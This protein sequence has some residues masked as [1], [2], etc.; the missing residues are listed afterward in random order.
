MKQNTKI[1]ISAFAISALAF[2]TLAQNTMSPK[3]AEAQ[4]ASQGMQQD[5]LVQLNDTA[6]ASEVIGMEVKNYQDEKLGT[7]KNL[8]LDMES[9]RVV[10]VIVSTGGLLGMDAT[11]TPVPP[12]ALHHEVGQN[13][14]RIDSS[15]DKFDAAPKCDASKWEEDT[16]SNRVTEVYNYYGQ[17]PYYTSSFST[18]LGYVQKASKLM[19][20]PV[21]NAQGENLGKIENLIVDLSGGR[22]VAVII[23]SG[24]Y[25]GMDGE[26]SA[27]PPSALQYNAEH[28]TLQL[29]ASKEMLSSSPHFNANEWPNFNQPAY[30]SHVYRAYNVNP[31]FNT[32]AT[33]E[34][35]NTA[36]N[37]RDRDTNPVTP[38]DQGNNQ[39]DINITAQIRKE[40][41]ATQ[42]MSMNAKN[43]K[44]ITMN[45]HVTLRGPVNSE[46]EKGQIGDIA[47]R[48]ARVGNVDNQIEVAVGNNNTSN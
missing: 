5:R 7:V 45:G 28:D 40:I 26:L 18:K 38:L 15:K 11:L 31:Y 21:N 8:A 43:V 37:I 13:Y 34:P 32:D 44:I 9:G 19:G 39:A 22:I 47:N 16:Q 25:L 48:I 36:K 33:A 46:D 4:S 41:I 35:D 24:G 2:S 29:D 6:K 12:A 42:G 10:Q 17:Q 27:V 20:A 30:A 23:S 1:I 3:V 14:F